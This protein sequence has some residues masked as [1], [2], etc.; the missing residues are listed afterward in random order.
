M[1]PGNTNGEILVERKK[2]EKYL[3]ILRFSQIPAVEA[4]FELLNFYCAKSPD[5]LFTRK[6]VVSICR[7]EG[8]VALT[9]D[10]LTIQKE[11]GSIETKISDSEETIRLW[12]EHYFGLGFY[13]YKQKKGPGCQVTVWSF[14]CRRKQSCRRS[15]S[16]GLS[17]STFVSF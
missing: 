9:G 14:S 12:M 8:S 4:D 5:V 11:D 1:K 2:E 7:P 10:V 17:R 13:R 3:P 15:R 16:F 6:R